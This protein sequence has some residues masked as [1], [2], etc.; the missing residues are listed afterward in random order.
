MAKKEEEK[1]VKQTKKFN[2]IKPSIKNSFYQLYKKQIDTI[3]KCIGVIL[4]VGAFAGGIY[5]VSKYVKLDIVV[6]LFLFVNGAVFL[7]T[8]GL[9]LFG[10][11]QFV[12]FALNQRRIPLT[13]SEFKQI[14]IET[15]DE[16]TD[17]LFKLLHGITP[18]E[19]VFKRIVIG[20]YLQFKGKENKEVSVDYLKDIFNASDSVFHEN[21]SINEKIEIKDKYEYKNL[22]KKLFKKSWLDNVSQ[23]YSYEDEVSKNSTYSLFVTGGI[24]GAL[25]EGALLAYV[26]A[27]IF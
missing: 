3:G 13:A 21:Y 26:I 24:I 20:A 7:A 9:A 23:R 22:V 1:Q 8:F 10:I 27:S 11:A 15:I 16:Y 19:E 2:K 14:G 18:N 5:Y 17:Y 6:C 4:G 12:M 25:V